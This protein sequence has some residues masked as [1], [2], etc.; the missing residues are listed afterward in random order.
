MVRRSCAK[1]ACGI[2]A[3]L[4]LLLTGAAGAAAEGPVVLP[5]PT[6]FAGFVVDASPLPS[7]KEGRAPIS[8]RFTDTIWADDDSHPPAVEELR[9]SLDRR[10]RL[11]LTNVPRCRWAPIQ[12]YPAF[13][14]SSCEKATVGKGPIRFEVAFPE[15]EPVKVGAPATVYNGRRGTMLIHTELAAPVEGEIVIPVKLSRAP[16]TTIYG[17][18]LTAS[19]PKV[20][21]GFGSLVYLG[22]R[23]RTGVFS[24][25][26]TKRPIQSGLAQTFVDGTQLSG[27]FRSAC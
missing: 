6:V 8:L 19:I 13:D 14:W 25:A 17:V 3:S 9:L 21:G 26:C 22:L 11:E 24:I 20:A 4:V 2:A 23:F 1:S 27:A 16:K 18:R 15:E 5:T 12:S 10:F 7:P